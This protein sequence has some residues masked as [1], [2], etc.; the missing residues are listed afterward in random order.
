M[1]TFC[2]KTWEQL[3]LSKIANVYDGTHQTPNYQKSGI[4]FL[5]VENIK[6]LKSNKY[7]SKEDFEIT[8]KVYP[9]KDDILM[10]R[11]G[12][13]GTVNIVQTNDPIAYY[14]SLALIKP[15]N[16]NPYFLKFSISSDSVQRDLWKRTLHI[17]FPKKIN[18]NEIRKIQI[19]FPK[20]EEQ[21]PIGKILEIVKNCITL[22]QRQLDLYKKLKKGLLQKLFPK[23]GEKVP[24]VRFANFH[25]TWEQDK[26]LNRIDS[27]ID[28]RGKTPKKLGMSWSKKGYLALS[29]LNV[30][31]GYI[32]KDIETHYGNEKLYKKWMGERELRKGQVLFTT[33]APMGNVAQIPD[34]DKYIL[35]QRTIAFNV[36]KN[37][38][39]NDFLA[40]LLNS[41]MVFNDLSSLSSGGTAKGVSQKSLQSLKVTMPS[42]LEEQIKISSFFK[43]LEK[44][45]TLQQTEIN[46]LKALK[47]YLLQKL[48]I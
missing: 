35:S 6:T 41:P 18:K 12:D 22:Q 20:E 40:I 38:I 7:I 30:K 21:I 46:E 42:D 1:T 11:I 47:K 2:T 15:F 24:E 32:E 23:D 9:Q 16:I 4:M 10:T 31:N 37:K 34:D 48:F 28:F 43:H 8:Y 44:L 26:F 39:T 3:E 33:E 14:V 45:L 27:I 13:I 17:A 19:N 29:A 25:D 36:N 5:S